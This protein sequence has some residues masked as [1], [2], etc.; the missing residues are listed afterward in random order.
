MNLEYKDSRSDHDILVGLDAKFDV[1]AK[2]STDHEQ[3]LRSLEK[4]KYM[5]LG[6]ASLVGL[7]GSFLGLRLGR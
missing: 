5:A 6:V 1:L 4:S 7:L 3:R 2:Q